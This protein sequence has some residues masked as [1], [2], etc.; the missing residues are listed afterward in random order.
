MADDEFSSIAQSLAMTDFGPEVS[1][2]VLAVLMGGLAATHAGVCL[3]DET[4]RIRYVNS[5]FRH[6]FFPEVDL[7]DSFVDMTSTATMSGTR[8]W[9]ISRRHSRTI[10]VRATM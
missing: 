2:D 4:D 3:C 1:P 5:T 10:S 8:C 6:A 9:S 7:G